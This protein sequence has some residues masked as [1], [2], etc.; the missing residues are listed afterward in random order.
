MEFHVTSTSTISFHGILS[1]TGSYHHMVEDPIWDVFFHPKW[2]KWLEQH[3]RIR[4]FPFPP[5]VWGVRVW[6]LGLP[7][8]GEA[9]RVAGTQLS[10]GM[11]HAK[12]AQTLRPTEPTW[13][14]TVRTIYFLRLRRTLKV[15]NRTQNKHMPVSKWHRSTGLIPLSKR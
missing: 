1:L 8:R 11:L 12:T 10:M 5:Q 13:E 4:L 15:V 6:K 9:R 2:T 3:L 7:W 14:D